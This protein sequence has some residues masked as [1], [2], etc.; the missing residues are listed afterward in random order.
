MP[1]KT[2]ADNELLTASDV[3]TILARQNVPRVTLAQRN[4]IPAPEV[5]MLVWRTDLAQLECYGLD[6]AGTVLGWRVVWRAADADTGYLTDAT[7]P[8]PAA[9]TFSA[10]WQHYAAGGWEGVQVRRVNRL[11]TIVGA[12]H[13]TSAPGAAEAMFTLAP[14]FRPGKQV[15]GVSSTL[16]RLTVRT[17]GVVTCAGGT[18]PTAIEAS[19]LVA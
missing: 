2:F 9:F 1:F 10:G 12:I 16:G 3:N 18:V 5:G 6:T 8:G 15:G 11:V 13:K 4:A 17:D 19:F 14:G 7:T